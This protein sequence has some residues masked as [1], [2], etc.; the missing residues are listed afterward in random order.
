MESEN[1][2]NGMI[3]VKPTMDPKKLAQ[4]IER[5]VTFG[6]SMILEDA[7]ETFDPLIEPVLAKMIETKGGASTI[8]LSEG[9]CNYDKNFKFY[10]TTK[11]PRPHYAPEVCVKV[12][13]LNF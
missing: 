12:T 8:K 3:T 1:N 5:S 6:M 11:L 9:P 10:I 7:T 4:T 2:K 13:M